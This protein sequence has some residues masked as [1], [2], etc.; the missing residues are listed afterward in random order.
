M[1][2]WEGWHLELD[3]EKIMIVIMSSS[4]LLFHL[5]VLAIVLGLHNLIL[6]MTP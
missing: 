1:G 6:T 5:Y 4:L 3:S 2:L